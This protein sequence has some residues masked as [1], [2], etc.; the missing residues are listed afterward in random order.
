[1]KDLWNCPKFTAKSQDSDEKF[2][3]TEKIRRKTKVFFLLL[4]KPTH[5]DT[6]ILYKHSRF[7]CAVGKIF[8]FRLLLY[9][10]FLILSMCNISKRRRNIKFTHLA[11]LFSQMFTKSALTGS[12]ASLIMIVNI[13]YLDIGGIG[14]WSKSSIFPT[15]T[16]GNRF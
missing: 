12:S 2:Q 15:Q 7:F 13:L 8:P 4:F 9:H 14:P 5:F 3:K 1:M 10:N 6:V 16:V 11:R